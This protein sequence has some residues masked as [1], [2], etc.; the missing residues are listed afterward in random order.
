[1]LEVGTRE[2]RVDRDGMLEWKRG[3]EVMAGLEID[4]LR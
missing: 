4:L 2:G 1:M 3:R